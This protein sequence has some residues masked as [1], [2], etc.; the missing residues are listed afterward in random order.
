MESKRIH[1]VSLDVPFP[2]D[3]GGVIDIYHRCAALKNAGYHVVLHC[4]EY[5]R[6]TQTQKHP[7]ADEIHY[8]RRKKSIFAVFSRL[9]FIVTTRKNEKLAQNLLRDNSPIVL[10]GHHCAGLLLDQRFHKRIRIVRIHNNEPLYYTNL[11]KTASG[12]KR[13]F[14]QLE[15]KKLAHFETALSRATALICLNQTEQ[16]YYSSIH[17]KTFLAPLGIDPQ[18]IEQQAIV[19]Q[20]LFHGNLSVP[21]NTEVALWLIALWNKQTP[22]IPL[23]L[24]GKNPSPAL[25]SAAE[26]NPMIR[27]VANPSEERMKQLLRTSSVHLLFTFQTTGVKV[28]LIHGLIHGNRCLV[29]PPILAGTNLETYGEL[30]QNEGDLLQK[31][32]E[33]GPDEAEIMQRQEAVRKLYSTD[34]YVRIVTQLVADFRGENEQCGEIQ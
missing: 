11:A 27:L 28:K 7:I 25:S 17:P 6:G 16:T 10:E 26:G 34:N 33:P 22:S 13:W 3:Y 19:Q 21:E 15:A 8:Y 18:R 14:F 12:W 9:P 4:F 30:I 29:N 2:P 31:L 24:A 32:R 20:A 23:I 1:I 5:G